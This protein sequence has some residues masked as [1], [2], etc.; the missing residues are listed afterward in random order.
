MKR[1]Y[2]LLLLSVL[3]YACAPN[4]SEVEAQETTNIATE[5]QG[6]WE[7]KYMKVEVDSYQNLDSNFVFEATEELWERQYGIRPFRTYFAQDSTFRTLRRGL[8]GGTMGEERGLWKTF[9][10]TLLLIQPNAT[11]Q[12][13]VLIENGQAKWAGVIDWDLDGVDDDVYYAEYR[14]VGRTSN[15]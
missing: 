4:N 1:I 14:F 7:V 15:E 12:Y 13:K 5:I 11:L 3:A 6:T 10:D 8:N 9:G 2:L